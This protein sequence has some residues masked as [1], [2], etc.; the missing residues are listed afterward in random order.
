MTDN[1]CDQAIR[2]ALIYFSL[3]EENEVSLKKEGIVLHKKTIW[4]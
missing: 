3:R 2:A 1:Q 4:K